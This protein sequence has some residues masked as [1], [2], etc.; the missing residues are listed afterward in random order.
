MIF[1]WRTFGVFLLTDTIEYFDYEAR[2]LCRFS[3]SPSG[4]W[5]VRGYL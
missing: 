5:Y 4:K 2:T 3:Y 1:F